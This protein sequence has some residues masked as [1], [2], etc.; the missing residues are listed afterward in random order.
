MAKGVTVLKIAVTGCTKGFGK[1][2]RNRLLADGH[3][4]V[5]FSRTSGYDL[6]GGVARMI[7]DMHDC[8]VLIN[9]ACIGSGQLELLACFYDSYRYQNKKVI[10]IGSW[11]TKLNL[12]ETPAGFVHERQI[13]LSLLDLTNQINSKNAGMRAEYRTWG[14]HP[15][16]PLLDHHPGLR[17]HTTIEQALD[18]L[19]SG[20]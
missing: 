3:Q 19:V 14:F 10:S 6:I 17:D 5:D 20:L 7:K 12:A 4:V 1:Y 11:V 13:K 16:H 15:G 8:D 2:I 18:Q 9:N